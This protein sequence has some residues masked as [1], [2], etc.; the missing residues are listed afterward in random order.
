MKPSLLLL[1]ALSLSTPAWADSGETPANF[2]EAILRESAADQGAEWRKERKGKSGKNS[3]A[4]KKRQAK[5][6]DVKDMI[7][8]IIRYNETHGVIAPANEQ[9]CV[10]S[11]SS[12]EDLRACL[13]LLQDGRAVLSSRAVTRKKAPGALGGESHDKAF[14]EFQTD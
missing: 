14:M 13:S 3:V 9:E 5:E 7:A 6:Q 4:E 11:S 8:K 1:A 12:E 2:E 10:E